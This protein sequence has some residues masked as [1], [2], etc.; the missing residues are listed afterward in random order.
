MVL[1]M[2]LGFFAVIIAINLVMLHAAISTF[3]G[4]ATPSSYE[5]GLKFT[6]EE[7]AVAAQDARHWRVDG[8][9]GETG[10]SRTL[11]VSAV[12]AAGAPLTHL[13]VNARFLHPAD[14]R[15]DVAVSMEEIAPGTYS[16]IAGVGAGQWVLDLTMDR[17]GVRQF[18]SRN[19]ILAE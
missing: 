4:T 6:A 3:G 10:G 18:H 2:I 12:D 13:S 5:A 17:A 1:A 15:R 11:T 14:E 8:H 9:L 16:G 19:R 7:A